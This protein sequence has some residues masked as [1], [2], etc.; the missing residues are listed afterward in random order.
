M[1]SRAPRVSGSSWPVVAGGPTKG[2]GLKRAVAMV[3]VAEDVG[4]SG[5]KRL[6]SRVEY[7]LHFEKSVYV[8][9]LYKLKLS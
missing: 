7:V 4:V 2:R 6:A 1:K 8:L 5:G 3:R 9:S